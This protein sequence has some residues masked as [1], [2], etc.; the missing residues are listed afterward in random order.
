MKLT[1]KRF[2]IVWAIVELL[3]LASS[4]DFA[5]RCQSFGMIFVFAVIQPLMITLVIFKTTHP[6]KALA[7]LVI[8]SLY[9][10]Y[11]IYLRFTHED[12][13][14]W[15]WFALGVVLPIVQLTFLLIY[16][17]IER[18]SMHKPR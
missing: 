6:N 15:G 10:V 12:T 16:W 7:N 3:L 9:T 14:G 11:S 5:V 1:D 4:I 2:W 13:D 18:I 17:G 8:I